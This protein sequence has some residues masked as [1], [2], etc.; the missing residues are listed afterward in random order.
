[1]T[2]LPIK[3]HV[4]ISTLELPYPNKKIRYCLKQ[5]RIHLMDSVSRDNNLLKNHHLLLGP[6]E[7]FCSNRFCISKN[8]LDT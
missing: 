5:V 7:R 2:T 4:L 8:K 3:Y 6:N 1:M